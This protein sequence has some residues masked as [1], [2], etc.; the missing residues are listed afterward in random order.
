MALH[1]YLVSLFIN[2]FLFQVLQKVYTFIEICEHLEIII[3]L[4][5]ICV[6]NAVAPCQVHI[7]DAQQIF[8]HLKRT[9]LVPSF[10]CS[11]TY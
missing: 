10:E 7:V 2:I 4:I 1:I 3:F 8:I 11:S 5:F 9:K 6:S